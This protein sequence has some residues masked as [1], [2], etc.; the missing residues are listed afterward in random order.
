MAEWLTIVSW[1]A[2]ILG[3]LTAL[4]IAFDVTAIGLRQHRD[5]PWMQ[6]RMQPLASAI[7]C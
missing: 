7:A 5:R 4:A 6:H 3:L 2:V 1:V